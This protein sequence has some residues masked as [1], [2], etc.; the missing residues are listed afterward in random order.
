MIVLQLF[1]GLL[2]LVVNAFF[3]GAEFA[4]IS[5]RRSQIEPQAEAGDR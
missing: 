1:I 4:L 3:V 2:T 5:V